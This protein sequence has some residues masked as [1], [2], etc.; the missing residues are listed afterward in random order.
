MENISSKIAKNNSKAEAPITA[1]KNENPYEIVKELIKESVEALRLSQ[2]VY[3]ILEKPARVMEVSIPVK[4]DDGQIRNFTGYRSQHIDIL[5]P[6]K[7]GIRFHPKVDLDEVKALSIWMSL[8]SAILGL[9]FGGGKGGVIVDPTQLSEC[10]LENLSRSYIRAL[11]PIIGP[12]K[13]IPAPDVNTN[14]QVMGWMLDEFDRLRGYNVPGFITGKPI[15]IGGSQGR[16]EATGRG[17]VITIVQA[18]KRLNID[19]KNAKAA[20]QGFGNV[21]SMTAKFLHELGVKIIGISDAS[22]GIYSQN[23]IDVPELIKYVNNTKAVMNFP[24]TT[25]IDNDELFSLPV[26]ILVPAALENQI[27]ERT[28]PMIQAKI[29]AEAANGPTTPAG[30]QILDEKGV[31]I[32]PD[33]LCNSGGV[34]VSYFEWVQNTMGFYW[35]EKDV[36]EKLEEKMIYAF[37]DVFRMTVEKDIDMRK[38]SYMVGVGRIAEALKARGWVKDWSMPINCKA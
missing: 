6:T 16:I 32:I 21:G 31:F 1:N 17:V 19:L 30:D 8:K 33:I 12:E 7:G 35:K 11:I 14:P 24:G 22:G 23:G 18:A 27:T 38:A 13:D 4:M 9:P 25:R 36:N 37:D 3:S 5:G 2:G 15:I 26:D 20:I 28:A 34:T 10:E 29:V